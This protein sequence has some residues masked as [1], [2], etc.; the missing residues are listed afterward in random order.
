MA[1][2]ALLILHGCLNYITPIDSISI[3]I[4]GPD[5]ISSH[6]PGKPVEF[7]AQVTG[8]IKNRSDLQLLWTS[9]LDGEIHRETNVE[10]KNYGFSYV[11]QKHGQH[12]F[13][14]WLINEND[15]F[16]TD[17]TI[18]GYSFE[19][20]T[21]VYNSGQIELTWEKPNVDR[22]FQYEI[23]LGFNPGF[24]ERTKFLGKNTDIEDTTFTIKD[25]RL[26]PNQRYFVVLVQGPNKELI[27]NSVDSPNPATKEV[28][29]LCRGFL[30]LSEN[31]VIATL[32]HLVSSPELQ[33]GTFGL[34]LFDMDSFATR[35]PQRY[36]KDRLFPEMALGLDG[37]RLYLTEY[38]KSHI[39]VLDVPSMKIIQSIQTEGKPGKIAIGHQN[40]LYYYNL[41][42][43]SVTD[44]LYRI[45]DLNANALLPYQAANN[46]DPNLGPHRSEWL[47]ASRT[48]PLI[49]TSTYESVFRVNVANDRLLYPMASFYINRINMPS[50][51][52]DETGRLFF[53]EFITDTALQVLHYFS[54]FASKIVSLSPDGKTGL[55]RTLIGD[56]WEVFDTQNYDVLFKTESSLSGGFFVGN[57]EVVFT[58]NLGDSRQRIFFLVGASQ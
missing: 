20:F 3:K 34:A 31:R 27:S 16:D 52:D 58:Q 40:R 56:I 11:P 25:I 19:L 9:S 53:S 32:G 51:F 15:E 30:P 54:G 4:I 33:P 42:D 28:D 43:S 36:F 24:Q 8:D 49:F 37:Q 5:F 17:S 46:W 39:L 35:A 1:L 18:I 55:R 50:F 12:K 44:P 13:K 38:D 2:V 14:V 7:I 45:I 26:L 29:F 6:P 21:P 47:T 57:N 10:A 23:W 41:N 48:L 22:F